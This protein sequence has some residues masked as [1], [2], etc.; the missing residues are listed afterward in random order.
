MDFI[1]N[2]KDNS[3]NDFS[4]IIVATDYFTKWV[5]AIPTKTSTEK[6]ITDFLEERIITRFGVP[7]KIVTDNAQALCSTGMNAF[8]LKYGIILSHVSDYYPQGNGQAESSNKNLMTI[9]KKIVEENK[10]SWDS[11]IKYVLWANRIT[12]KS[13]IRKSH[14]EL[15]YGLEAQLPVHLALPV[16]QLLQGVDLEE[17]ALQNRVNQIIE[18]DEIRRESYDQN[19][20]SKEKTKKNVDKSIGQKDFK[21][22][23]TVLVWDKNR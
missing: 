11:K 10:M 12:K 14:F 4:W 21:V 16:Y 18:L 1:G 6:V 22:G 19:L 23:D 5:E 7:S 3:S 13:F 17:T 9:I 8:C 2:F 15:V 20:K